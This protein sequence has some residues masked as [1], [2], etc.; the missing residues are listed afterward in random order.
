MAIQHNDITNPQH[1][2]ECKQI[3]SATV[4]DAGKVITPSSDGRGTLRRLKYSELD[5]LPEEINTDV[6]V[7]IADSASQVVVSSEDRTVVV[8]VTY[9]GANILI[10]EE[11]PDS[12]VIEV[13]KMDAGAS[14]Q[15]VLGSD[16]TFI[17]GSR[18]E[19]E[20]TDPVYTKIKYITTQTDKVVGY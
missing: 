20:D 6:K 12:V 10:G 8:L 9:D 3:L 13:V 4:S 18:E 1:V 7:I 15:V 5:E 14:A 11:L 16:R 19:I 17:A 2:H